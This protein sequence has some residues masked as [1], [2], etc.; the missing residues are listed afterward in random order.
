MTCAGTL[1]AVE[2]LSITHLNDSS[3]LITWVSPFT[4]EFHHSPPYI[5][6]C[7]DVYN[8]NGLPI[9]YSSHIFSMCN[10]ETT[11]FKFNFGNLEFNACYMLLYAITPVN[12]AGN[13]TI[14]TFVDH[15][16]NFSSGNAF[17]NKV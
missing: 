17:L 5:F 2:E 13:G 11:S 15:Q 10:H 6:Y 7:I 9:E 1:D 12:V 16:Q 3:V 8:T 14:S 4:F